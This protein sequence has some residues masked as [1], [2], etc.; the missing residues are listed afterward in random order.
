MLSESCFIVRRVRQS[1]EP[2]PQL[3]DFISQFVLSVREGEL[4]RIK[5]SGRW[6]FVRNYSTRMSGLIPSWV[7]K[8]A[9]EPSR[10]IVK[11][12]SRVAM[13]VDMI[14]FHFLN[15]DV[16]SVGG[17]GGDVG[18]EH[19][20]SEGEVV[21]GV[22]QSGD[23]KYLGGSVSFWT[24]MGRQLEIAGWVHIGR[25]FWHVYLQ[26]RAQFQISGLVFEN[27]FIVDIDETPLEHSSQNPVTGC[28]RRS[29][30]PSRSRTR[31]G[32]RRCRS[33]SVTARSR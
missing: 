1:Y 22:E 15:G 12:T 11:I 18:V 31:Y 16:W 9:N 30:A 20:L 13:Y 17:D 10:T 8:P 27:G 6:L 23:G 26:S 3:G 7:L 29:P 25:S 4:I 19:I 32:R 28:F 33:K 5:Q 2:D 21:V 14:Q 24:S